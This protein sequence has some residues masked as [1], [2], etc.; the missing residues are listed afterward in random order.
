MGIGLGVD[1]RLLKL[2]QCLLP[3]CQDLIGLP[4]LGGDPFLLSEEAFARIAFA[5]RLNA[6][7]AGIGVHS[8]AFVYLVAAPRADDEVEIHEPFA[9]D[10]RSGEP[11]GL[12][13]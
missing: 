3:R 10:N 9:G 12:R 13:G 11:R 6:Q 5:H 1:D 8:A 2:V 7:I 4:D